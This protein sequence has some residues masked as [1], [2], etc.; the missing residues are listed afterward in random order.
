MTTVR[1]RYLGSLLAQVFR[2]SELLA[3]DIADKVGWSPSRFSRLLHGRCQAAPPDIAT[4]LA[5]C[6]VTTGPLRATALELAADIR[7][8]TWLCEH[9]ERLPAEWQ[10]VSELEE[11]ADRVVCVDGMAIPAVL[12]APRYLNE[13]LRAH[14]LIP[15]DEVHS[16]MQARAERQRVVDRVTGPVVEAYLG[17][18]VLSDEVFGAGVM[19]D[20]VSHLLCLA[21]RPNIQIRVV[22]EQSPEV[23][24]A[25]FE[26]MSF[27]EPAPVV[28]VEHLNSTLLSERPSTVAG[29]QRV[30]ARLDEYALSVEESCEVLDE[31]VAGS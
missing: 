9:G 4:I 16:R 21:A 26:L 25:V 29:Y 7:S 24:G 30:V 13:L 5:S 23:C 19:A 1:S 27:A 15:R 11:A 28:C 18:E 20:Q 14:P 12:Q 22:P 10:A 17:M 6:G 2:D 8:P 31:M 3:Q